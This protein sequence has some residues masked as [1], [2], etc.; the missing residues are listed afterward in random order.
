MV[1]CV[2]TPRKYL[3]LYEA[4]RG[5]EFSKYHGY[6]YDDV[7]VVAKALDCLLDDV[8]VSP[9][10]F[11]GPLVGKVLNKTTFLGDTIFGYPFLYMETLNSPFMLD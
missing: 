5:N 3:A 11:R 1:L 4:A 10:D 8:T 7:W 9:A 2:Q 6:A